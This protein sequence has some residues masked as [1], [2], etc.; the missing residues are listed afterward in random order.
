VDNSP[1]GRSGVAV[2]WATHKRQQLRIVL[3]LRRSEGQADGR[4][5]IV[6]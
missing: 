3:A 5:G 2:L 1:T 6:D 4:R